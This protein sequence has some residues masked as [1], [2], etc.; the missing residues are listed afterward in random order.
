MFGNLTVGDGKQLDM[1]S[2]NNILQ[3]REEYGG[4]HT[5]CLSPSRDLA[6][7][8]I[9]ARISPQLF[10]FNHTVLRY[11][12]LTVSYSITRRKR[13]LRGQLQD[14]EVSLIEHFCMAS[15]VS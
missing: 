8:G 5:F 2:K 13:S 6:L 3:E 12:F 1:A 10:F 9:I 4:S 7:L 11:R 14:S 15:A